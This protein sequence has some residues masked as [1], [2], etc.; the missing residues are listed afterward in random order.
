MLTA[1]DL[2]DVLACRVT[3]RA[4][5]SSGVL[6][7]V[8]GGAS[9]Q[10]RRQRANEAFDRL[11]TAKQ[12]LGDDGG[13]LRQRPSATGSRRARVGLMDAATGKAVWRQG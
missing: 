12:T 5:T 10:E 1:H 9:R 6:Q 7:A 4:R 8:K 13:R 11:N 2:F 3:A